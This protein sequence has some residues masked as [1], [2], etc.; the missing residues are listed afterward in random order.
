MRR[1]GL[2]LVIFL[3]GCALQQRSD[4]A[5]VT[6]AVND[7]WEQYS[8]SLN[9]GDLERWLSLWTE[10]GV[11]MP[12]GEPPVVGKERIRARNQGFLDRF[13]FDTSITNEEVGWPAIGPMPGVPTRRP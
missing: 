12:P 4:D 9:A 13:T 11:Q 2:G 6:A 1:I 3:G 5:G 7:V 8:A 10:D